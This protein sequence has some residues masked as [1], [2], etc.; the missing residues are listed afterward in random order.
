MY[1]NLEMTPAPTLPEPTPGTDEEL[2]LRF[3]ETGDRGL[4]EQLVHRY[5]RELY[6]YLRRYLSDVELAADTFQATFLQIFLKRAQFAAGRKFR[7]WLYAVAT[8]Q[9]IDAQRRNRRHRLVSLDQRHSGEES[10]VGKLVDLLVSSAPDPAADVN[11]VERQA[12]VREAV[13]QLPEI[14]RSV[15]MLVYYQG[16]KYGDAAVALGV[17]VGTVKSRLHSA[18][19]KLSETVKQKYSE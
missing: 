17:P 1:A 3:R 10:D 9:A 16:L 2:F 12:V 13:Q 19:A 15:V 4:F 11:Q 5:E 18:L 7:P 14:L 8:N 6:S